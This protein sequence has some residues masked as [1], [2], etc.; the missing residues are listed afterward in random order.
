MN[1]ALTTLV[2][3]LVVAGLAPVLWYT[4]Q[5]LCGLVAG[6]GRRALVGV[7]LR[8]AVLV[9]AHDEEERIATAL[10]SLLPLPGV[11][12]RVF[13]IADNCTDG[14]AFAA[15]GFDVTVLERHDPSL[16]GKG[17]A[18]AWALEAIEPGGF[19]VVGVIDAD[20]IE[21]GSA[22]PLLAA[23]ALASNRPVQGCYLHALPAGGDA[24]SAFSCFAVRVNNLIRQRGRQRLGLPCQV[25]GSGFFMPIAVAR[26]IDW[27]SGYL[28]EDAELG[29][30]LSLAGH[31][32][33]FEEQALVVSH[34]PADAAQVL[35]QR[36]G[37]LGGR[38]DLSA[39][40]SVRS[41]ASALRR[42]R[43]HA[44]LAMI[45]LAI[46]ST[47]MLA[48]LL[49]AELLVIAAA[50]TAGARTSSLLAAWSVVAAGFGSAIGLAWWGHGRSLLT[51]AALVRVPWILARQGG[52]LVAR[53]ACRRSTWRDYRGSGR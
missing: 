38:C 46:P 9:P 13:V 21:C 40:R 3:I 49:A 26:A 6:A 25:N 5:V 39:R 17:H 48:V 30:D 35:A 33:L 20:T 11:H 2:R 23:R 41:L 10:A 36:S 32:P 18:L 7:D 27:S 19:N 29:L 34:A 1:P 24:W 50:G 43:P 12:D 51:G 37:W 47:S 16:F 4:I 53:L 44:A 14:T 31:D 8:M 42:R 15:S 28:A 22:V 45:D 52:A